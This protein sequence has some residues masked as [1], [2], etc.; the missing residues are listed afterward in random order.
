M[1]DAPKTVT[2]IAK[3][4]FAS[5][6]FAAFPDSK[7]QSYQSIIKRFVAQHGAKRLATMRPQDLARMLARQAALTDVPTADNWL[8]AVKSLLSFG[9]AWGSRRDETASTAPLRNET[10]QTEPRR[11]YV[12][13]GADSGLFKIGIAYRPESRLRELQTGSPLRVEL[14]AH[15]EIV[16]PHGSE[17]RILSWRPTVHMANGSILAGWGITS[18]VAS[19]VRR[20]INRCAQR[21]M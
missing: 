17:R 12:I 3:H 6:R 11:L 1:S 15:V 10:P 9:A 13:R 5:Q 14:V 7:R 16:S 18:P 20:A 2:V 21:A 19:N 4:Y 8:R